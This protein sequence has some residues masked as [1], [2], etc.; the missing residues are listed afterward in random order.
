RLDAARPVAT[1][2]AHRS[3]DA[4]LR[5]VM[6]E[7][8]GVR[9]AE[10]M[11]VGCDEVVVTFTTEHP[12]RV[13][14]RVGAHTVVTEGVHH[15]ARVQELAPDTAYAVSVD[16]V[17]PDRWLPPEVRTLPRPRGDLLAVVATANDVHFGEVECG[18]TGDRATDAIGPILRAAPGDDPYPEVMGRA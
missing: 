4:R 14:T 5:P 16:G 15:F 1:V 3:P 6:A 11:S 7:P 13:A 9:F 2:G 17:V 12:Q 10:L 18:R 8:E